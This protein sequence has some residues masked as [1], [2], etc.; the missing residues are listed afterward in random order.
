MAF[1][2][3]YNYL[4]RPKEGHSHDKLTTST[5]LQNNRIEKE[6]DIKK[7]RR[8]LLLYCFA[9]RI[10]SSLDKLVHSWICKSTSH[11]HMAKHWIL[12][13]ILRTP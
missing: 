1:T 9:K 7:E 13:K 3:I 2:N 12:I 10:S 11:M 6:E 4:K 5:I 8:G